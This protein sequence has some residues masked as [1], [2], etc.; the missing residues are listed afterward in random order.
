[1]L[2]SLPVIS[3]HKVLCF[4]SWRFPKGGCDQNN[5]GKRSRVGRR[6]WSDINGLDNTC[7]KRTISEFGLAN[8]CQRIFMCE[9]IGA[10]HRTRVLFFGVDNPLDL[11]PTSYFIN[12]ATHKSLHPKSHMVRT[13]SDFS[14]TI[15]IRY[16]LILV[17]NETISTTRSEQLF[18]T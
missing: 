1:M 16:Q 12:C 9:N 7:S 10:C 11:H 18:G 14:E 5:G 17:W 15:C 8:R 3:R 6:R 4:F 2:L 13:K